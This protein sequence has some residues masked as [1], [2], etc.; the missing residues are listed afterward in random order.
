VPI[1]ARKNA[2]DEDVAARRARN[3]FYGL[4]IALVLLGL[5]MDASN[6]LAAKIVAGIGA[7]ILAAGRFG[8]DAFVRRCHRLA[9]GWF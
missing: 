6:P 5:F 1:F 3:V 2:G 4:G 8:S 9:T 7:V